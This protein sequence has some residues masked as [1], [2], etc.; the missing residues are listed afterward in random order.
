TI[1][2]EFASA[3]TPSVVGGSPLAIFMLIKE[4]IK[5]GR[6]TAIVFVTI[7]LDEVF[8]IV[9][10]PLLL[11]VVNRELIFNPISHSQSTFGTG[12]IFGFWIG[13]GILIGYTSFLAFALFINPEG[14]A[15]TIK[16]IF[17]WRFFKRWEQGAI[18]LSDD[19]L[20][21]AKEFRNKP[22]SFWAQS[23]AATFLAWMGRYLVLN[24]VLS[25]FTSLSL[26]DHMVAFA[27]QVVMFQVM[28]VS[29]TPGGSGFAE[30]AF[31]QMMSEF[32]PLGSVLIL[33]FLWRLITYY[34][35]MFVGIPLLPRWLARVF[36]A[37]KKVNSKEVADE[38]FTEN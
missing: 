1:L 24:C 13:Y 32:A 7:F 36:P 14:T 17:R 22:L 34:P 38:V 26:F 33:A 4:K 19:L 6:S 2:W 18:T 11:L 8:Y 37:R 29:P 5:A 10:L 28:L 12:L 20:I 16:K 3:L 15:G 35:Y 31:S 9:I 25:M 27:R 21:S 30:G 23:W